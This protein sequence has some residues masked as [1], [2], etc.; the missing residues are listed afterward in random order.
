MDLGPPPPERDAEA[1]PRAPLSSSPDPA[2]V[3]E[4]VELIRA[5]ECGLVLAGGLPFAGAPDGASAIVRLAEAAAWPLIAEPTSG[6]RSGPAALATGA[7]L[8]GAPGFAASHVPDLLIQFGATPTSRAALAAA[9][10]SGRLVVVTAPGMEADPGRAAW[11][12]VRCDPVVLAAAL[13]ERLAPR[14]EQTWRRAWAEADRLA[15][16]AVAVWMQELGDELFEGRVARD[17]AAVLP[18]GATL[19]AGSSMPIRDLDSFMLPRQGLRVLGNRG[20]SGIDGSVSTALGLAAGAASAPPGPVAD[21]RPP[22]AT[23]G[24]GSCPRSR[25]GHPHLRPDRRSRLPP[26]R[27]GP[28]LGCRPRM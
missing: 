4:L 11:M 21:P 25:S 27:R 19:F 12:T 26:R 8:L 17:L 18:D 3:D 13:V 6:A 16:D 7:L 15:A 22:D 10:G 23:G 28:V 9:A 5:T 2:L 24:H 20:A 14:A 1:L